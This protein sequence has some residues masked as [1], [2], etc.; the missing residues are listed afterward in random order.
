MIN[1]A[2]IIQCRISSTRLPGKAL[3]DLGGKTVFQWVLNSMKKVPADKYMVATDQESYPV[4]EP[5]AKDMGWD[6]MAGPLEDVLERYCIAIRQCECETVLRATA[7]N[8]FLFYEAAISLVEEYNRQKELGPVDYMTWSGLPHGCGVEIFDS[9]ALLKAASMTDDPYDHEHVGPAL[10]NH[11]NRFSSL[12]L[13][14]PARFHLPEYRTTIDTAADYRRAVAIVNKLSGGRAPQEPYTTEQIKAAVMEPSVYDTVLFFPVVKRGYGTGHLRRCLQAAFES[15]SFIYIP[16]DCDLPEASSL[17]NEYLEA[18]LKEYQIVRKFPENNEYSL[19]A[20]DCFACSKDIL[21]KLSQVSS[22]V[23]IDEGSDYS[24]YGDYILDIIPSYNLDRKA[25]LSETEFIEKPVRRK[26][27]E[28]G[29]FD[30]ILI[31]L[32]GEDPSNLT[33]PAAKYFLNVSSNVDAIVS[34]KEKVQIE[35]SEINFLTPVPNLREKLWEYDLVVTHYGLTAFEAV[36]AGCAVILLSTTKLHENLAK[37][38]GFI[39][40]SKKDL[41][42]DFNKSILEDFGRLYP[43]MFAGQ[44]NKNLGEFIR[45][46]SHGRKLYCPVCQHKQEEPDQLIART[47]ERTFRRCKECGMIYISWNVSPE[48]TY[49]KEYFAESYKKQYGKTYLEDFNSIKK[50]CFRRMMEINGA[51]NMKTLAKPSV[52]DIG[53][54]Y[55]PF[56]AAASE[57]GW[58]PYGTDISQ[59]AVDYVRNELLYPAVKSNFPDFDAANEFG[60]N[61]FEAVTMWFV[62]EHFMDLKSVLEKVSSL[63]KTGG[64]FAFSTPSASGVSA[65][66]NTE[67]FFKQSPSD[68]YTLWEPAKVSKILAKY[69]FKVIKV[70]S[71]GHHPER[72]PVIKNNGVKKGDNMFK[73]YDHISRIRKLGDTFEVYCRKIK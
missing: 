54:A 9:K 23:C 8:P 47:E 43:V 61:G 56:L 44:K 33:I 1:L 41:E 28:K 45:N 18:G 52:L 20:T 46:L 59:E 10:Y 27:P 30:K 70:V 50:N 49:D 17:V 53:C 37:K 73:L 24:H 26:T 71:T 7:D 25:N 13:K 39:C 34:S 67:E 19:I 58:N 48:E 38:Y 29:K 2:V 3:K 14:A 21:K 16:E 6:I 55:G 31:C 72:F 11:K 42:S 60:V 40:L 63:V 4:L 68:H 5:L 36:C 65:R 35:N 51:M 57:T 32:G 22:V 62:I 12:F 66:F 69:G 64:V 15:D